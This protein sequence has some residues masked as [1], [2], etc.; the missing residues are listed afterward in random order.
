MAYAVTT[1]N[2]LLRVTP[3]GPSIV[4]LP[5][6][7]TAA[8]RGDFGPSVVSADGALWLAV[9]EVGVVHV[10][11]STG[12]ARA[13]TVTTVGTPVAALATKSGVM[14]ATQEGE[15]VELAGGCAPTDD[16]GRGGCIT[17]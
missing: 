9:P 14:I 16:A 13:V 2:M 4:A 7:V 8:W 12:D 6:T 17:L 5:E 3:E 1:R 10:P 11:A 15:L